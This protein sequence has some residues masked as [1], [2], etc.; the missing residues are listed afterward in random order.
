[1]LLLDTVNVFCSDVSHFV[2]LCC[3]SIIISALHYTALH[4]TSSPLLLLSCKLF[5]CI[6]RLPLFLFTSFPSSA[7]SLFFSSF[8]LPSYPSPPVSLSLSLSLSLPNLPSYSLSLTSTS[9]FISQWLQSSRDYGQAQ[10]CLHNEHVQFT[11][12]KNS[13][14]FSIQVLDIYER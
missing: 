1:M 8:L 11:N 13:L 6:F 12:T 5:F 7:P 4:C 10:R 2:T 14:Y 3:S 9:V